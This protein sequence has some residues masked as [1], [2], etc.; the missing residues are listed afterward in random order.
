V[1]ESARGKFLNSFYSG[2][3]QHILIERREMYMRKAVLLALVFALFFSCVLGVLE[4]HLAYASPYKNV[5]VGT[6]YNMITNGSYPDLLVLDVRRRDEY[7]SGHIYGAVWIPHTELEVRIS[8]LAG[9]QDHEVIVY[10]GSGVRSAIASEILDSHGFTRVYNMVG[11]IL[12]WQSAGYPVWI[13]TVH[14]IDTTFNYDTIQAAI[15]APQTSDGHTILVETGTYYEKVVVSKSLTLVGENRSDTIIDGSYAGT[16]VNIIASNVKITGFTIQKS[17]LFPNNGIYVRGTSTGNNISYNILIDNGEAGIHLEDSSNNVVSC[18]I[19]AS[20]VDFGIYLHGS[21][22]NTVFGNTISNNWC[23][24]R[25]EYSSN[26]TVFGNTVLNNDLGSNP[27]NSSNNVFFHNSFVENIQQIYSYDSTNV[28]DNGYP[29]GGNYWSDY[30]GFDEFSGTHQNVIGSD[31]IG[32]IPYAVDENNQDNY[33]LVDPWTPPPD[34][35][36]TN[37]ALSKTVVCQGYNLH[38]DVTVQNQADYTGP[39]NIT[40]YANTTIIEMFTNITVT[41]ASTVT[42]KWN[43]TGFPKG[44]YLIKACAWQVPGETDTTDNTLVRG[45]IVSILGDVNGDFIDDIF[46]VVIVAKAFGSK[47]G[48]KN[49]NANADLNDDSFID[50][51]DVVTVA[52]NFGK[53][54][55]G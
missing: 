50:I 20:N 29:S 37:I 2:K 52:N 9:H 43:T 33:P 25:L 7:D 34:I 38:I 46:D 8:E 51:Y 4:L 39:F 31:G 10:C 12:D 40:A 27:F 28:W 54:N 3:N 18:N 16:V 35:A 36:V 48:E 11:G 15:E 19:A 47:S 13:A 23:G 17:G 24:I 42:F 22:N 44:N 30:T 45:V 53:T 14:N 6:A 1:E 41:S 5:D 55:H 49:W 32:D 26:N 21:R